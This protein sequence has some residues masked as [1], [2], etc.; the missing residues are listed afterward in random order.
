M[1][2]HKCAARLRGVCYEYA[3]YRSKP[4]QSYPQRRRLFSQNVRSRFEPEPAPQSDNA[5]VALEIVSEAAEAIRQLEEQSA[6]AVTRAR[7]VAASIVKKLET[8]EAR[9]QRAETALQ[10]PKAK[11][12]IDDDCVQN[13]HDPKRRSGNFR[14][15]TSS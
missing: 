3:R 11:W 6:E 4:Q 5:S 14:P 8:T 15:K 9:A 2:K 13:L 7:E 10:K 1:Q 12:P